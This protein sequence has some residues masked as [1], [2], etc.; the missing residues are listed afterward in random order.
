MTA[1][2]LD[3]Y[4]ARFAGPRCAVIVGDLEPTTGINLIG[5]SLFDFDGGFLPTTGRVDTKQVAALPCHVGDCQLRDTNAVVHL[6]QKQF[7]IPFELG[8]VVFDGAKKHS[9]E[10]VS[11][12]VGARFELGKL[13]P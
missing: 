3:R 8:P 5:L 11:F 6:G 13:S 1:K 10:F 4:T 9:I 2:I 7:P 12:I